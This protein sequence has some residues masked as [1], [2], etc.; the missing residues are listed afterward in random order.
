MLTM[1]GLKAYIETAV[2]CEVRH[3]T[4][5]AVPEKR[6]LKQTSLTADGRELQSA[7]HMDAATLSLL[8]AIFPGVVQP[9]SAKAIHV[10]ID[11]ERRTTSTV[12]YF[13]QDGKPTHKTIIHKQF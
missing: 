7:S 2:G 5:L 3:T 4:L 11:W 9:E 8:A 10:E 13:G 1:D 6:T 12:F